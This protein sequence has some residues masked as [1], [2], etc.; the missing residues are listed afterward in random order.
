MNKQNRLLTEA[1]LLDNARFLKR[2][3]GAILLNG[4]ET[5]YRNVDNNRFPD[6]RDINAALLEVCLAAN[7]TRRV[8]LR[9]ADAVRIAPAYLRALPGNFTCSCHSRGMVP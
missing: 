1:I 9:R 3:E 5:F 2:G 8:K 7:E 4:L 6:L